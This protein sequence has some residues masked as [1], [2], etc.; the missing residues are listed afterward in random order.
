M[1]GSILELCTRKYAFCYP[2]EQT[3]TRSLS[4]EVYCCLLCRCDNLTSWDRL[5]PRF[6]F[7]QGNKRTASGCVRSGGGWVGS[8]LR[9]DEFFFAM[10]RPF[11]RLAASFVQYTWHDILDELVMDAVSEC[12]DYYSAGVF[13][14]KKV[15]KRGR[16]GGIVH[17]CLHFREKVDDRAIGLPHKP[18]MHRT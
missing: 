12:M 3:P 4:F 11:L 14:F 9:K 8:V 10:I 6:N 18:Y 13:F 16:G 17:V 15:F 1:C 2:G 7:L 5:P